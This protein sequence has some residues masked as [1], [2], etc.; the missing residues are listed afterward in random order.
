ME[1]QHYLF[2][3]VDWSGYLLRVQVSHLISYFFRGNKLQLLA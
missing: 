3:L 1:T 2:F